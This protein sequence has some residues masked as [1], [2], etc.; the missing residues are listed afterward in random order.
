MESGKDRRRDVP[1]ASSPLGRIRWPLPD[2]PLCV[3]GGV[4]KQLNGAAPFIS[5]ERHNTLHTPASDRLGTPRCSRRP[6]R[7]S[8]VGPEPPWAD[9]PVS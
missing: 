5:T 3:S 9:E 2:V 6:A 7:T 4:C 8:A 1:A